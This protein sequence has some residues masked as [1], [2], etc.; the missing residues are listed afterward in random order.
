MKKYDPETKVWS[1]VGGNPL[2]LGFNLST[3]SSIAVAI[4]PDGTP[5]V[6]YRDQGDQDYPK[7]IYLDN[8]TKQWSD[9]VKLADVASDD[10]D[11]VFS[12]T[13]VGYI[14]FVDSDNHVAVYKYIEK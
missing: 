4:A 2:P 8:E 6:A 12:S 14:S 9:P 13:G 3:S 7:V 11:I 10:I 5:F 1:T